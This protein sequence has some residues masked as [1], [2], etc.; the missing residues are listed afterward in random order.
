M[1]KSLEEDM[2]IALTSISVGFSILN[3]TLSTFALFH[4]TRSTQKFHKNHTLLRYNF[5]IGCYC[6]GLGT[7]S[8]SICRL[9]LLHGFTVSSTLYYQIFQTFESLGSNICRLSFIS[10]MLERAIA[11]QKSATYEKN[12]RFRIVGPFLVLLSVTVSAAMSISYN[13]CKSFQPP[14][15]AG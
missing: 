4:L 6:A 8:S 13:L 15:L 9:L 3:V 12:R 7:F 10:F 1:P 2:E 5:I 11:T 14:F